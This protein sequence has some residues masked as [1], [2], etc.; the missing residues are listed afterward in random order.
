MEASNGPQPLSPETIEALWMGAQDLTEPLVA[1]TRQL[2]HTPSLPGDE[3]DVA[4][5]VAAEMQR[6]DYDSVSVDEA[7][8]VI[9]H[10]RA[11]AYPTQG[12]PRRSIMFN[13]HMD[14]VDVGDVSRWPF[15][16]YGGT[17]HEGEIWGRGASDLKGPLAC[18]VYAGALLKRSG[19]PLPNDVYVT[20]V[21]QEEVG[22]L[23]SSMLAGHLRTDYAVVGEPSGNALALG[24]RGR[25]EML[26]TV[27]G[28]SVHAS[29]PESGINPLYSLAGFL[30]ALKELRFEPD[31]ANPGL[32]P[33]SVAPTL[34][35]TDQTSPNVVPGECRLVLD[36]RTT[37][38][39]TSEVLLEWVQQLLNASLEPGATGTATIVPKSLRSY[40]GVNRTFDNTVPA[41]GISPQRPLVREAHAALK[42]ALRREVPTRIWRFATD[43][44]HFVNAGIEVIG[45]GPGLE[46]VIHTVDERIPVE[47][48]VEAVVA[49]AAIALA[50]GRA[51]EA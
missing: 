2:I 43:A 1:F 47:M 34:I 5:L 18:Q 20:G 37:P 10:I 11:N 15:P 31:P 45:F 26:V 27:T 3:R 42:A 33:T 23:G 7:G 25:V 44:G 9:G 29:V 19:L 32:G 35:T 41:F 4:A 49:N 6:L 51:A 21:V 17:L 38:L 39:E 22:G 13:T 16:P 40:T 24:H 8:N 28:K 30:A 46:E 48:M 14:H 36:F 50:V 12:Q